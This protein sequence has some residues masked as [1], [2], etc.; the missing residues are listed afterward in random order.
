V[1]K[2][3]CR[4]CGIEYGLEER[5]PDN[6]CSPTAVPGPAAASRCEKCPNARAVYDINEGN[7]RHRVC[8]RTGEDVTPYIQ[9]GKT[10]SICPLAVNENREVT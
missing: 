2:R 10:P 8:R 6:G 3:S 4:R 1:V 5:H 9:N 7:G